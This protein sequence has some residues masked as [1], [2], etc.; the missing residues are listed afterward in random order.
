[1][2]FV[3]VF[4]IVSY[5]LYSAREVVHT[6]I[7]TLL[8]GFVQFKLEKQRDTIH[9]DYESVPVMDNKYMKQP[10]LAGWVRRVYIYM[11]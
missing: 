11:A 8:R 4:I 6:N 5:D 2:Y 9:I 3:F 10:P 7:L 1:M